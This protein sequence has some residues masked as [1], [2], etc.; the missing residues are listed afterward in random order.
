LA[1]DEGIAEAAE[2]AAIDEMD[3]LEGLLSAYRPDS[4]WSR[5]RRGEVATAGPELSALL[6]L[7]AHWWHESS[8]AFHPL[9]GVLR[10]RWLRAV[11]E[12]RLPGDDE[13]AELAS[14]MATLPYE[15]RS[16]LV[17]RTG[18]CS[19]LDLHAIA[20]GWIVDRAV[21]LAAARPGVREVLLNAG[22]DLLHRGAGEIVVGVQ[23]PQQPFDNAAPLARVRLAD[24][25]LATS[26]DAHR[27]MTIGG[28]AWSHV[29]DP[30]SGRPVDHVRS[31]TVVAAD[32]A[33]ADALAT[34]VSVLSPD[35]ALAFADRHDAAVL[36]VQPDGRTVHNSRW[37]SAAV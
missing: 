14:R 9:A 4:E 11:Q 37:A 10:T 31:A 2:A 15:L 5:W 6:A 36:L 7:A 35:E 28:R 16:G 1:D 12:Q 21:A 34:V 18:D 32:A 29:V 17:V 19:Q 33:T 20:K 27:P 24:A 23:D 8:G 22:G 26:G 13:L 3:R 25:G 30:R